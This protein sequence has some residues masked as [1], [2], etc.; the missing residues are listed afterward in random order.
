[1]SEPTEE[2][3]L[4]DVANHSLIVYRNDGIYRHIRFKADSFNMMFELITW[5]GYLCYTGDMGTYVFRR[6]DDMF[7]FFRSFRAELRIN[8]DYW[9]EKLE[10]IDRHSDFRKFSQ[11]KFK[12]AVYRFLDNSECS[13]EMRKAVEQDVNLNADNEYEARTSV[14][15]FE[16]GGLNPFSDFCEA[17][18]REYTYRFRWCCY[19]IAWGIRVYD[20]MNTT[21]VESPNVN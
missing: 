3:F 13:D 9:S 14:S 15:D 20:E 8:P 11:Q 21:K 10:S 4:K 2:S 12:E 18:L 5:P 16:Y 17:D 19:A 6:M 1:M 7:A